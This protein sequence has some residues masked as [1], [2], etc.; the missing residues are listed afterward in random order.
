[1]RL[2]FLDHWLFIS[3]FSVVTLPQGKKCSLSNELWACIKQARLSAEGCQVVL[4]S[5][6]YTHRQGLSWQESRSPKDNI[7][8]FFNWVNNFDTTDI[9]ATEKHSV[10]LQIASHQR[11]ACSYRWENHWSKACGRWQHCPCAFRENTGERTR[12]SENSWGSSWP[13][14][15]HLCRYFLIVSPTQLLRPWHE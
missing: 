7:K 12:I 1:M 11:A 15:S 14:R 2:G 3:R 10:P 13:Q 4:A 5:P 8:L 6:N 9:T